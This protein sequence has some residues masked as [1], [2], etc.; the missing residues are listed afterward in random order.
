MRNLT[1]VIAGVIGGSI[2]VGLLGSLSHRFYGSS[3]VISVYDE[4]AMTAFIQSLPTGA[5]VWTIVSHGIGA[6]ASAFIAS[7]IAQ[8]N[9]VYLGFSAAAIMLV[10]SSINFFMVSGHPD[11][12][13]IMDPIVIVGMAYLG[14]KLGS[15]QPLKF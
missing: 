8:D 9:K 3:E 12:L 7:K 6:F 14:S 13:Y 2:L 4:E 10:L 5:F 15:K 11:W 1:S